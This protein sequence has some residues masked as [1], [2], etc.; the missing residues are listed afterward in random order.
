MIIQSL[1]IRNFRC[2]KD[3]KFE[4]GERATVI[5][6]KNGAG[7]STMIH[8][9]HKALSFIMYSD[10]IYVSTKVDGKKKREL[11][12]VKTITNNNPYLKVEGYSK[13]GDNN[14]HEDPLIEIGANAII[15]G[16][17][18]LNWKMSAFANNCRLRP[19][20]FI[21]AFRDFYGYYKS[22]DRLPL[23]A[24]YSDSFPHREDNKK[25][26]KKQSVASLRN[27]GYFD[28]NA[29]EGC[30]REW[31]G[32]LEKNFFNLR[33]AKD[34]IL[35][36]QQQEA[37]EEAV[38]V[39]RDNIVRWEREID[40]IEKKLV[41][42]S[43]GLLTD[44]SSL[45]IAGIDI[46]SETGSLCV[47]TPEGTEVTFENLPSGYK[48]L[49]NIV[50]DLAYRS[51]ILSNGNTTDLSGIAIID[52]IDLHLHPTLEGVI[53]DRF[54]DVFKN[55]QFIVSTH[56][57]NLLR[58]VATADRKTKILRMS[59]DFG[60]LDYIEDIFGLDVSTILRDYMGVPMTEND[61]QRLINQCAYMYSKELTEQ[62]DRLKAHIR[63]REIISE[64]ELDSR[65]AKA[66]KTIS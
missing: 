29:E 17:P 15:P 63:E 64:T 20:E 33:Q 49:F 11:K 56:S 58:N 55:V 18:E 61:L 37:K 10:K 43:K 44:D 23:I 42:F 51:Y 2:F 24:Y 14:N 60:E 4:F 31:I 9:L 66:L 59:R 65:I 19:S 25:D 40:T 36:F 30:S 47:L 35:K 39:T 57:D 26:T 27:F 45:E 12:E 28:W 21:D 50:L 34:R 6:G 7:K 53:L 48:R 52:E 38:S 1:H 54:M 3:S 22:S 13:L 5:F 62:A 8:A 32:R 46:H 41:S 16:G